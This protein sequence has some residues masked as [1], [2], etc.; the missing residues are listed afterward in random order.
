MPPHDLVL[1][2]L[3]YSADQ[4]QDLLPFVTGERQ[5]EPEAVSAACKD[6]F[7]LNVRL[8]ADFLTGKKNALDVLATQLIPGWALEEELHGKLRQWHTL[9]SQHAMHMSTARVPDNLDSA[10][11]LTTEDWRTMATDALA[12]YQVFLAAYADART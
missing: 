11:A 4:V 12:A 1:Q 10:A 5:I 8:I 9:I 3:G 7:A 2:H 6:S